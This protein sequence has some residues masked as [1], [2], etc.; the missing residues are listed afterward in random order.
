MYGHYHFQLL[1]QVTIVKD[2]IYVLTF[3]FLQV[4]VKEHDGPFL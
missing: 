2:S 1:S 3:T 4:V